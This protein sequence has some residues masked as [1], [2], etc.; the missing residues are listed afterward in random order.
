MAHHA[1]LYVGG[2]EAGIAAARA[3]LATRGLAGADNPDISVFSYEGTLPVDVVRSI[4]ALAQQS[5]RSGVEKAIIIAA[6][7]LFVE[8]QNALLKTFEEPPEGTTLV[9]IIP[10]EGILL[11]TLRSRLLHLPGTAISAEDAAAFLIAS[12]ADRTKLITKLVAKASTSTAACIASPA[13]REK[14]VTKLLARTKDAKDE[15]KQAA[16]ME[17]MRL[18]QGLMVALSEKNFPERERLLGELSRFMPI[19][20]TSSAPLKL[21]FEH[22]LLVLPKGSSK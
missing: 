14:I 16:R 11:P 15:E 10:A 3:F 4:N 8:S 5:G 1:Y 12:D 21:I 22:L 17:A 13:E 18:C 6:G 20:H 2:K 7:R 19:L 9:L